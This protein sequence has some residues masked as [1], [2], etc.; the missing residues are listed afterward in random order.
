MN[1]FLKQSYS[2][3]EVSVVK[4]FIYE[5]FMSQHNVKENEIVSVMSKMDGN[6]MSVSNLLTNILE[7]RKKTRTERLSQ[8]IHEILSQYRTQHR[9][10]PY[11][12]PEKTENKK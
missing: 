7:E 6:E 4:Q 10:S 2:Q 3:Q 8:N 9:F 12:V 1:P 5:G 11:K